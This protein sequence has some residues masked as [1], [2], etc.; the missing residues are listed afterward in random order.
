MLLHPRFQEGLSAQRW[1]MK[2]AD[3]LKPSPSLGLA[4]ADL[5][6][7]FLTQLGPLRILHVSISLKL[8]MA[9]DLFGHQSL[10]GNGVNHFQV[11]TWRIQFV[12]QVLFPRQD[13]L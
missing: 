7:G 8:V 12:I 6:G 4:L 13:N 3:S 11:E 2:S 9:I 5:P 10:I 1:G